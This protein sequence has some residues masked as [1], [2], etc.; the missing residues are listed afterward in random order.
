MTRENREEGVSYMQITGKHSYTQT[1]TQV[2]ERSAL[3]KGKELWSA[4]P[5]AG[6]QACVCVSVY[7]YVCV[8]M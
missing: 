4:Q 2:R 6:L 1:R 5:A 3:V 7:V 8:C